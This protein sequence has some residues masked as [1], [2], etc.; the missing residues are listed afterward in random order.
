VGVRSVDLQ[1]QVEL[2]G[3]IVAAVAA[4]V[5]TREGRRTSPI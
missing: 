5:A 4:W 3:G 2:T 1:I